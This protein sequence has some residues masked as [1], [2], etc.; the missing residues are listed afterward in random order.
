M[1]SVVQKMNTVQ[2]LLLETF[3]SLD[4]S[5]STRDKI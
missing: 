3:M 2:I 1:L 5:V 4:V